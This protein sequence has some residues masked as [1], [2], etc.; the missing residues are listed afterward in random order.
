MIE[1]NL[2]GMEAVKL[3]VMHWHLSDDQGFRVE[4]R[5]FPLLHEKGSNGSYYTQQQI[6]DVIEYAADRG[7][8]VVPE[9][10]MPCHTTALLTAYP[11]IGSGPGPYQIATKWGILD[12]A[13]IR[14]AKRRTSFSTSLS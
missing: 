2:D 1:R 12:A 3:N 8:R 9:F 4:S 10:D 11:Q 14:R 13:W 5:Q 7:I 6:K